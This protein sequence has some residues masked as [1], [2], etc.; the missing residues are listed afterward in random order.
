MSK[1]KIDFLKEF[2]RR[3]SAAVERYAPGKWQIASRAAGALVAVFLIITLAYSTRAVIAG[4]NLA[5]QFGQTSVFNQIKHLVS[6]NGQTIKGEAE[7]RINILLLGIGGGNHEGGQL[8]D[9]IMVASLRP[10]EKRV[11][12]LSIPRDLVAPI[13]GFGWQKIN[14]AHAFGRAA[15]PDESAA[16]EKLAQATVETITGL[17]IH[18]Y[19]KV[20]FAGFEKI[21]N[22]LGGVR[23]Y[24]PQSFTDNQYPDENF[25]YEPVAFAG[26]WQDFNGDRALKYARSRHGGNEEGSDF[27]RAR[28][29]QNILSAVQKRVLALSTLLNPNKLIALSEIVGDHLATN[30]EIWESFRLFEIAKQ[31]N[32]GQIAQ[33]VLSSEGA[34]G[35]LASRLNDDGAYI[36]EP[37]AGADNFQ[38]IS[39]LAANMFERDPYG[40]L[41]ARAAEAAKPSLAILN[42]TPYPGL[43]SRTAMMLENLSYRI[44]AIGNAARRDYERTVIY[45][46]TLSAG[47]GNIQSLREKLRANVAPALPDYIKA[48]PAD[49]L[50]IVGKDN[51]DQDSLSLTPNMYAPN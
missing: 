7:D 21:I 47:S 39:A 29:Q 50:I 1:P 46:L 3:N 30:L 2:L 4:K 42:G 17:P 27:A 51:A 26:G 10:S 44:T 18:Y 6:A 49:V 16:G 20:D 12:L 19:L 32:I 31:V 28:R 22:A 8:T 38:E 24:V 41:A 13:P 45:S 15:D 25:G 40:R 36:L 33:L 34:N 48:P 5:R 37:R 9:T 43:A 14:A 35:L 11:S 23:V